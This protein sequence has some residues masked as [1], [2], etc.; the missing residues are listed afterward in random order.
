MSQ[1]FEK[2]NCY[3]WSRVLKTM[4]KEDIAQPQIIS[5]QFFNNK[6]HFKELD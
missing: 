1:N 2:R 6:I 5:K 3:L 4:Y